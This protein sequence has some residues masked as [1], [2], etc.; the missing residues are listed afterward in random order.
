MNCAATSS[1]LRRPPARARCRPPLSGERSFHRI[2]K[3][4]HA[5]CVLIF[6]VLPLTNLMRFD[7][8]HERFYFA[9]SDLISRVRDPLLHADVPDVRHRGGRDDL[10]P[11]HC[12][13]LCPQMIFSEASI[14]LQDR[15]RRFCARRASRL[16][17]R[18]RE[19][20]SRVLLYA[21][22][23]AASVFFS[24][25]FIAYFIEPRRPAGAVVPLRRPDRGRHRRS[26]G[27][28]V[29]VSRLRVHPAALLYDRLSVRL[30]AESF[31]RRR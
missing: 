26:L 3:R 6:V 11:R 9:G 19:I 22:I 7:I 29:Y 23:G 12:G 21:A 31:R 25:V 20:L 18:T 8:P 27:H 17:P 5:V 15:L 30:S 24:F 2:R 4:V 16:K 14:A 13:Y 10:G 28:A 1:L